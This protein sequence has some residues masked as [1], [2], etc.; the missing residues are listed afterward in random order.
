[1]RKSNYVGY[2]KP[3]DISS[4]LRN[5]N[6]TGSDGIS[7]IITVFLQRLNVAFE[8]AESQNDTEYEV[9]LEQ[10]S[11]LFLSTAVRVE[12]LLSH[13]AEARSNSELGSLEEGIANYKSN[14]G[15]QGERRCRVRDEQHFLYIYV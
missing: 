1:M 15:E 12:K 14:K 9:D 2:F 8:V 10:L 7:A 5:C 3:I 4:S 6:M 13:L 11:Q